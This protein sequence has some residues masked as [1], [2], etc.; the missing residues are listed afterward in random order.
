MNL[1]EIG[2]LLA[3]TGLP[4]AYRFFR[5]RQDPPFIC[6]LSPGTD[7]FFADGKV[8]YP[9]NQVQI[10][11]YTEKKDLKAEE[12][13]EEAL[14]SFCWNKTETFIESE[15]CYQIMYEIEV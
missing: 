8:Y 11:L 5:K 14:S 7:N 4:V 13:V 1:K 3:K 9:V 2:D 12:S 6:Y 15:N 10:E